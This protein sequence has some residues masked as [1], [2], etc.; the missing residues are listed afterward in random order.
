MWMRRTF[1][2][3][4]PRC[5]RSIGRGHARG[6]KEGE[7]DGGVDRGAEVSFMMEWKG[8]GG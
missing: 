1:R 5:R 6:S 3:Y 7:R 4:V 8:V 2:E